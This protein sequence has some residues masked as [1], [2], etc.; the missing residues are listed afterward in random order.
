MSNDWAQ[1]DSPAIGRKIKLLMH[2][3]RA[4]LIAILSGTRR[5]HW[6]ILATG[7]L[8]GQTDVADR[9]STLPGVLYV[10]DQLVKE[11][12]AAQHSDRPSD[13]DRKSRAV[14]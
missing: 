3:D 1:L 4:G 9:Q 7:Y 2:H 14:G 6:P 10:W 5:E 13:F 8:L 11:Y 12:N